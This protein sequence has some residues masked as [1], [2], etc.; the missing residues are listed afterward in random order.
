MRILLTLV[1]AA[2]C[3]GQMLQGIVGG[4]NGATGGTT[5]TFVQATTGSSVT[6][7][8]T[9]TLSSTVTTGDTIFAAISWSYLGCMPSWTDSLGNTYTNVGSQAD[10]DAGVAWFSAPVVTGGSSDVLTLHAGCGH[11]SNVWVTEY[12]HVTGVLDVSLNANVY[13]NTSSPCYGGSL[14]T[15]TAGDL[16]I[17]VYGDS[18]NRAET[19]S[20]GWTLRAT[21]STSQIWIDQVQVSAGA[22]N[23]SATCS[24]NGGYPTIGASA[25]FKAH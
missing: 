24:A 18:A 14:T 16:V 12:S 22:I 20:A 21:T 3:W 5:P 1:F 25:A 8:S 17:G 9:V 6:D 23:P 19:P 4:K 15:A 10:G 2:S 7:G 11:G 13:S